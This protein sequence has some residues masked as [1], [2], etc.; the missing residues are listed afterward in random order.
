ML[1]GKDYCLGETTQG[2]KEV[3]HCLQR[4]CH[5]KAKDSSTKVKGS[6]KRGCVE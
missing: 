4:A 3:V 6:K 5:A 1:F 2:G